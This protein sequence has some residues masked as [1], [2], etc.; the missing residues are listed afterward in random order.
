MRTTP[1]PRARRVSNGI[2]ALAAS[3]LVVAGACGRKTPVRPPELVAPA[4]I[5]DLRA[6]NATAGVALSWGRP[7][8]TADG[9]RLNDLDAFALERAL[10]GLPFGFL[11]RIQIPDRDR[12]RQQKTFTYVDEA[13][14]VG[15]VYRYRVRS[16]TVDGYVSAPSNVVDILRQVPTNTPPMAPTPPATATPAR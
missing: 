16:V 3:A 15:E 6:A 2:V 4:T 12:L 10:P 9:Q 11:T 1:L 7:K 5:S 8:T 13:A 14:L